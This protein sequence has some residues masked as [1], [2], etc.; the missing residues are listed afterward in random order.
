MRASKESAREARAKLTFLLAA[1]ATTEWKKDDRIKPAGDY[2]EEFLT[3]V[4]RKLPREE[5]YQKGYDKLKTPEMRVKR[6]KARESRKR[7]T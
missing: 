2:L 6:K 3:K 4:E 1:L 7:I 5:T